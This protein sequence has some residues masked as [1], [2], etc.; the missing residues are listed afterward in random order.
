MIKM[1]DNLHFTYENDIDSSCPSHLM[2]ET[3]YCNVPFFMFS[4][5]ALPGQDLPVPYQY[6]PKIEPLKKNKRRTL[7]RLRDACDKALTL[8]A[9]NIAE[10]IEVHSQ[11]N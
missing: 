4:W 5:F 3:S 9:L 10:H 2:E 1:S 7:I 8:K 6:R 11:G